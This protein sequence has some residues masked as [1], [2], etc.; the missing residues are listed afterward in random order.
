MKI[1]LDPGHGGSDSGAVANGITEKI[2]NLRVAIEAQDFLKG[3]GHDVR[4]T[5]EVDTNVSLGQRAKKSVDWPANIF[6]SIHH[7]CGPVNMNGCHGFYDNERAPNGKD[8]ATKVAQSI[9][10]A[11]GINFSYGALSS[12]WFGRHLGV[13][14]NYNNWRVTIAALVECAFLSNYG[15]SLIIKKEGYTE[16]T[17]LAIANGIQAHLGLPNIEAV[18]TP[19]Q[20]ENQPPMEDQVS[21]WAKKAADWVFS[22][23]LSDCTRPKEP[24]TRE[25]AWCYLERLYNL[26][27]KE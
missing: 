1:L 24:L 6:L 20:N 21:P 25:E 23:E 5:R 2:V 17:G 18:I 4:M 16:R 15:N 27:K 26:I 12:D 11:N 22:N 3:T 13:L 10:Q 8:L 7:D 9:V 14:S 19:P